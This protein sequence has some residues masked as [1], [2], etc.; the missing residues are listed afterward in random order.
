[1]GCKVKTTYK[2]K[3]G[4]RIPWTNN[5]EEDTLTFTIGVATKV[6]EIKTKEQTKQTPIY[7]DQVEKLAASNY[8]PW[9]NI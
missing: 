1:M 3:K 4:K 2:Y 8:D 6:K 7:A 5:Y 9:Q